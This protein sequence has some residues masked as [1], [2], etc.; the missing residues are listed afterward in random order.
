MSESNVDNPQLSAE[1]VEQAEAQAAFSASFNDEVRVE[2]TPTEVVETEDVAVDDAV[3]DGEPVVLEETPEALGLTNEQ[4][5]AMLAKV[6]E[7]ENMTNTEIRKLHGKLGE[8]NRVL[9]DLKTSKTTAPSIHLQ[10]AKLKSLHAEYPDLAELLEKDLSELTATS[11]AHAQNEDFDARVNKV[12]ED[13]SQQMQVNLLQL[14]HRDFATVTKTD[15][16]K[17]W[18]QTL[19]EE[20]RAKLNDSWDAMYLG[21]KISDFKAW[22]DKKQTGM[23]SRQ[24]RLRNAITPKGT[25]KPPTPQAMTMEDGFAAAF[26]K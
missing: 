21:E 24:E 10:G 13:L 19:P 14:Q 7:L 25:T 9:Q 8:F 3:V 20:D 6:P 16:F 15:D 22:R 17:V 2:E 18:A 23:N 4:L 12:K 5:T 11:E 1:E 26:R